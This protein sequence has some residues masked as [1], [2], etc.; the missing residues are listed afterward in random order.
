MNAARPR[1][2]LIDASFLRINAVLSSFRVSP[3]RS[4]ILW[5]VGDLEC[6][7]HLANGR[8]ELQLRVRG[9]TTH[10]Q[11]FQN[12]HA[13]RRTAADWRKALEP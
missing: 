7:L 4:E 2:R 1:R 11:T 8:Y 12:E 5:A 13:A 10:L 6:L 9:R 3:Y